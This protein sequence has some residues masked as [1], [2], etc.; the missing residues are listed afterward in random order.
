MT[1]YFEV[2]R[3]PIITEKSSYLSGKLN[4]YVFEVAPEATKSMVKEAIESLFNGVKVARVNIVNVPLRRRRNMRNRRTSIGRSSYKKAI[5]TLAP[6]SKTIPVF[7][8][9]R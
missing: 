4:K 6:D 8:G 9:V 1:T 2:L 3:R 7:E 5:I